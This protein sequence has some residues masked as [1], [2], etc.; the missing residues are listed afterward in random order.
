MALFEFYL[1]PFKFIQELFRVGCN[2]IPISKVNLAAYSPLTRGVL[3]GDAS[4]D[5]W[6]QCH[7]NVL[8]STLEEICHL[9]IVFT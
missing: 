9:T 4:L 8:M 7:F 2:K 5:I 6:S 1:I 3:P